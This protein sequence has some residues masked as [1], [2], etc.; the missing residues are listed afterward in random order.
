MDVDLSQRDWSR[1]ATA[2]QVVLRTIKL[3]FPQ[4]Q[5]IFLHVGHQT[6]LIVHKLLK[7]VFFF[8]P[9]LAMLT[10]CLPHV[11]QKVLQPCVC[12][13]MPL[14]RTLMLKVSHT[15][16][17]HLPFGLL[18]YLTLWSKPSQ[19][20][21]CNSCKRSSNNPVYLLNWNGSCFTIFSDIMGNISWNLRGSIALCIILNML[22]AWLGFRSP[23]T[24]ELS[25]GH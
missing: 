22:Q 8:Q 25:E 11:N 24:A 23:V 6:R 13:N 7:S 2:S 17:I 16:S 12:I 19:V 14:Q 3:F 1:L 18:I 15:F 4:D 9:K 21:S 5:S 20:R 10:L